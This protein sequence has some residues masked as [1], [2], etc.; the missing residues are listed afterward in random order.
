M[1]RIS[2]G[3]E[4]SASTSVPLR[5]M[6]SL[7]LVPSLRICTRS[8]GSR[9]RATSASDAAGW[10]PGVLLSNS[11]ALVPG[12]SI[13][14]RSRMVPK[15]SG[16]HTSGRFWNSASRNSSTGRRME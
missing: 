4:C 7:S 3:A 6:A 12:A 16:G 9:V 2:H 1:K 15:S 10:A 8:P 13:C 5:M 11:A 14:T